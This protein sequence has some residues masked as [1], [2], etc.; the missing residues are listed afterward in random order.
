MIHLQHP[1]THSN[2]NVDTIKSLKQLSP[3]KTAGLKDR[4]QKWHKQHNWH[5]LEIKLTKDIVEAR[6]CSEYQVWEL[7]NENRAY[8]GKPCLFV[9][10]R[11]QHYMIRSLHFSQ[12]EGGTP[13]GY[14]HN[15]TTSRIILQAPGFYLTVY[16]MVNYMTDSK[17][18]T[19]TSMSLRKYII[20]LFIKVPFICVR[21][22]VNPGSKQV[23]IHELFVFLWL[24]QF[25]K[26]LDNNLPGGGDFQKSLRV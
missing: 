8:S 17:Y 6:M 4:K 3:K 22:Y 14:L 20:C 1:T 2:N 16:K 10:F 25:V 23:P 15:R 26:S 13:E 19:I 21:F 24:S 5:N 12:V 7:N 11:N 18:Q 9:Q